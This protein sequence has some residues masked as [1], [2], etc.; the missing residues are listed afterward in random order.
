MVAFRPEHLK[1]NPNPWFT[2]LSEPRLGAFPFFSHWS[3]SFAPGKELSLPSSSSS[4]ASSCCVCTAAVI[5]E[6]ADSRVSSRNSSSI[7]FLAAS[8]RGLINSSTS[9]TCNTRWMQGNVISVI[10]LGFKNRDIKVRVFL[11]QRKRTTT[12]EAVFIII[13]STFQPMLGYVI[14]LCKLQKTFCI[15]VISGFTQCTRNSH[16]LL[17]YLSCES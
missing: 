5:L 13:L 6:I 11:Q 14:V 2:P 7:F 16:N 12:Y 3:P 8:F 9:N 10:S 17:V 4:V 15:N 1:W